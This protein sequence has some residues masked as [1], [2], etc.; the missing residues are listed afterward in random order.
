[1]WPYNNDRIE[2]GNTLLFQWVAALLQQRY[3]YRRQKFLVQVE[4]DLT[5]ADSSEPVQYSA[6][7]QFPSA[8][9]FQHFVFV[10]H[11]LCGTDHV[12]AAKI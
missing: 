10:A 5:I 6:Q 11:V 12:C 7:F 9:P 4:K 3:S 8:F 2:S 1:M